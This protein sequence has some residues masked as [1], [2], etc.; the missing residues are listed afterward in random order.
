M[1]DTLVIDTHVFRAS[2]CWFR[3]VNWSHRLTESM[4]TYLNYTYILAAD[5]HH[6]DR[7]ISRPCFAEWELN[8]KHF[9]SFFHSHIPP[10]YASQSSW[11]CLLRRSQRWE[12]ETGHFRMED[13]AAEECGSSLCVWQKIVGIEQLEPNGSQERVD[14]RSSKNGFKEENQAGAWDTEVGLAWGFVSQPGK[15]IKP[16]SLELWSCQPSNSQLSSFLLT[17]RLCSSS[18]KPRA[19]ISWGVWYFSTSIQETTTS[20]GQGDSLCSFKIPHTG[21][22]VLKVWRVAQAQNLISN[23]SDDWSPLWPNP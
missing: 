9:Q 5:P 20:C 6:N 1:A 13:L 4:G 17:M 3:F 14:A 23:M 10:W 19:C 12:D 8:I 7:E 15:K 16:H 21:T 11:L 22:E 18:W 2:V